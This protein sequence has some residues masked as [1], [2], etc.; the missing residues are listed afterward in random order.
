MES[1]C[2]HELLGAISSNLMMDVGALKPPVFP[3]SNRRV[4]MAI[5]PA[6]ARLFRGLT[7]TVMNEFD[8]LTVLWYNWR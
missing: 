2:K 6:C 4:E 1:T 5:K 8:I 7:L 3:F